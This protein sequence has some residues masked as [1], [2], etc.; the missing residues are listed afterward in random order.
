MEDYVKL[1]LYAYPTLEELIT[2]YDVHIQNGAVLSYRSNK[3]AEE[4][5]IYLAEEILKKRKLENL[6]ECVERVL[7]KL[8]AVEKLLVKIRYFGKE[9]KI[10]RPL[11]PVRE[12]GYENWSESKYFRMQNKLLIKLQALF[13]ACGLSKETFEKEY[14]DDEL[15]RRAYKKMNGRKESQIRPNERCWIRFENNKKMVN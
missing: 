15:F 12:N 1:T 3:T 8:S 7:D 4:T 9:R 11:A 6:K 10:K 14:A 5:A 2:S 13:N